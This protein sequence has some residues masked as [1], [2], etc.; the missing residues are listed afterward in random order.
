MRHDE[1][2]KLCSLMRAVWKNPKWEDFVG[3]MVRI[4]NL[5]LKVWCK[6]YVHRRGRSGTVTPAHQGILW[7]HNH[8]C[9]CQKGTRNQHTHYAN[10]HRACRCRCSSITLWWR[11]SVLRSGSPIVWQDL[12]VWIILEDMDNCEINMGGLWGLIFSGDW[13]QSPSLLFSSLF[14]TTG[15][16]LGSS[17]SLLLL[18]AAAAFT[19]RGGW[20]WRVKQWQ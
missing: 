6:F 8:K 12:V 20:C 13:W 15:S 16:R 5:V 19:I 3:G 7:F 18:A 11:K 17:S 4:L 10:E 1:K 9:H 14:L 2:V